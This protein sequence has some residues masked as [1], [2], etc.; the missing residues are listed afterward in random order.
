MS[1]WV[2]AGTVIPMAIGGLLM[3]RP[4]RYLEERF[5][6]SQVVSDLANQRSE[7]TY[8]S[9]MPRGVLWFVG[10]DGRCRRQWSIRRYL[11]VTQ[12]PRQTRLR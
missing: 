6:W 8:C 1:L 7:E 5:V 10:L 9:E 2:Y 3:T 4:G 11:P 12:P